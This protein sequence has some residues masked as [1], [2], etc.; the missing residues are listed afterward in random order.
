M[1]RAA[2]GK[3]GVGESADDLGGRW[4]RMLM[5]RKNLRKEKGRGRVDSI[6]VTASL[7]V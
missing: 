7:G 2:L 3:S 6:S 5:K 1:G 4:W